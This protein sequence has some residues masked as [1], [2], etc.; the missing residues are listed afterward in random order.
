MNALLEIKYGEKLSDKEDFKQYYYFTEQ[1]PRKHKIISKFSQ[2]SVAFLLIMPRIAVIWND[3]NKSSFNFNDDIGLVFFKVLFVILRA[4]I[5][6]EILTS[7][8]FQLVW[9]VNRKKNHVFSAKFYEEQ[10]TFYYNK[11]VVCEVPYEAIEELVETKN[12]IYIGQEWI[13]KKQLK[14]EEV[15][16]IRAILKAKCVGRYVRI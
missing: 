7:V 4:I 10:V 13:A 16:C 14:E 8:T 11:G 3:M 15:E 5:Y 6:W 1:Y 12:V 9:L 2:V